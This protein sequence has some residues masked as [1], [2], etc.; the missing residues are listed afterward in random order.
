[1]LHPVR[2]PTGVLYCRSDEVGVVV[3]SLYGVVADVTTGFLLYGDEVWIGGSSSE[4]H[5]IMHF[6]ND[7]HE[8][9]QKNC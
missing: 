2:G 1:M 5:K 7:E 4:S 3:M 6:S 9:S 8:I